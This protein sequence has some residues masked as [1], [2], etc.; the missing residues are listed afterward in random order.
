[1]NKPQFNIGDT[2]Y[3]AR[4]SPHTE[5]WVQCPECLG[6]RTMR[7]ILATGEEHTIDCACC[8]RGYEGSPGK[9]LTWQAQASVGA[10]TITGVE[11]R[12]DGDTLEVAYRYG[13]NFISDGCN[14]FATR[15]EAMVRA[16]ELTAKH[17]EEQAKRVR[18]K[19]KDT[20]KWAW[21]ISYHRKE[22]REAHRKIEY[23]TAKLNAA[24][25]QTKGTVRDE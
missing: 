1:M 18:C 3:V 5:V 4:H 16:E 8:E 22:I 2:A 14:V 17:N 11:S 13:P 10:V 25:K 12:M 21:N 19:E 24:P 15:D 23:H 6:T 20:R 7:V 9:I